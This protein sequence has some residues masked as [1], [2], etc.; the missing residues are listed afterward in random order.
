MG[1]GRAG[2]AGKEVRQERT[3]G[4]SFRRTFESISPLITPARNHWPIS[5]MMR[6]SKI[7][8]EIT[9]SNYSWSTDSK[10]LQMSASST[11]S[12]NAG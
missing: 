4:H 7:R 2:N 1:R 5:L 9:R 3:K 11:Q 10:K 8:W 6:G 12:V